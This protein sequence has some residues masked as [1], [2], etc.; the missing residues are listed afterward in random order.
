LEQYPKAQ[1]GVLVPQGS[2]VDLVV[3]EAPRIPPAVTVNMAGRHI[4]YRNVSLNGTPINT[5]KVAPGAE[6]KISFVYDIATEARP[7]L[8]CPGCI[9]Q[10][11]FGIDRAR[12]GF[13]KCIASS[14]MMQNFR[15]PGNFTHVFRAPSA[16]GLYYVTSSSTLEMGCREDR[17]Q[18]ANDPN[19]ALALIEVE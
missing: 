13:S 9:I 14:V 12:G 7:D 3:A 4:T 16:K 17:A 10:F 11:Y 19:G 18:H 15:R 2:T 5:A 8:Y 6:V 1:P